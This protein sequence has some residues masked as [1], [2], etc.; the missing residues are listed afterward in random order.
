MRVQLSKGICIGIP[1]EKNVPLMM[2]QVED[3]AQLE[4]NLDDSLSE[5]S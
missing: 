4:L 5:L 3:T 2:A 1:V